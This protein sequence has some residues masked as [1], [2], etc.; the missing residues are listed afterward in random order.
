[1]CACSKYT[2]IRNFRM[3]HHLHRLSRRMIRKFAFLHAVYGIFY[4]ALTMGHHY[5]LPLAFYVPVNLSIRTLHGWTIQSHLYH[6]NWL[7]LMTTSK[8]NKQTNT[9][10]YFFSLC[11][12]HFIDLHHDLMLNPLLHHRTMEIRISVFH[13]IF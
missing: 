3:Y 7:L 1:M 13:V 11:C 4:V 6:M 8:T 5:L 2:F 9:F 12:A 10:E